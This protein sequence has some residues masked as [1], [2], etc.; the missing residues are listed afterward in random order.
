MRWSLICPF[1]VYIFRTLIASPLKANIV[2]R[3]TAKR[4]HIWTPDDFADLGSRD[5]VDKNLQRLSKTGVIRRID[6]GLYDRPIMNRL[7]KK[8][9]VPDYREILDAITRRDQVRMLVDGITAANDIGLTDAVPARVVIHTD[10][11]RRSI[12]IENLTIE[13]KPTAPSKLYWAGRPGMRVVQAL[14]WAKDTLTTDRERIFSRLSALLSD[15]VHGPVIRQDLEA[16]LKTVPA[17][18]QSVIRELL[19]YCKRTPPINRSSALV[20]KSAATFSWVLH[21]DSAPPSR[22]LKK[23]SGFVGPLMRFSTDS[24]LAGRACFSK[25]VPPYPK[26]SA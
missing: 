25:V 6:R 3:I 22:T 4:T 13:F 10:T 24:R 5:A 15:P 1:F 21:A 9:T 18:M 14:H 7:T 23:T 12:S 20:T 26:P 17:W 2:D 19:K 8:L 11:R 16:G